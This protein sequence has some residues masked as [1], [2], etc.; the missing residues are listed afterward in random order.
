MTH[1]RYLSGRGNNYLRRANGYH[2]TVDMRNSPNSRKIKFS[3]FK[4]EKEEGT[5]RMD[6][7]VSHYKK[8]HSKASMAW[9][10]CNDGPETEKLRISS[11]AAAISRKALEMG[12]VA[13]E[14]GMFIENI[15]KNIE[16]N[17]ERM[18]R[19][20]KGYDTPE[21]AVFSMILKSNE[22]AVAIKIL[23]RINSDMESK[24][25]ENVVS[26]I[27]EAERLGLDKKDIRIGD[28]LTVASRIENM[29]VD[30]VIIGIIKESNCREGALEI[31]SEKVVPNASERQLAA[32]TKHVEI[33]GTIKDKYMERLE[34]A[35]AEHTKA[36]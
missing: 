25:I 17:A 20:K 3:A 6:E 16:N 35:L 32:L 8:E 31:L 23:E 9:I 22:P 26:I 1:R 14:L 7:I 10:N 19:G 18:Y 36:A 24:T 28:V 34:Q 2:L 30:V 33:F 5:I 13:G 12:I 29:N 27:K 15:C 21:N 11:A 4:R